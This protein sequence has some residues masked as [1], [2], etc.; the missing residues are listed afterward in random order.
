MKD[1]HTNIDPR[2]RVDIAIEETLNPWLVGLS[3][4]AFGNRQHSLVKQ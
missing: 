1:L 2:D 4:Q 3:P